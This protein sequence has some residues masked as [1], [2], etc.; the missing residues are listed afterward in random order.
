MHYLVTGGGGYIGS[1][2]ARDLLRQGARVTVVDNLSTGSMVLVNA[3]QR[4]AGANLQFV[5]ADLNDIAVL[6]EVFKQ[7]SFDAVFHFAASSVVGESMAEPEKYR[8]NNV[9]GT[10]KLL[11]FCSRH[12]VRKFIFS[13]T[14]SVYGEPGDQPVRESAALKPVSVYG[15]TKLQCERHIIETA[16]TSGNFQYMIFR[17]FNVAGASHDGKLGEVTPV[18]CHLLKAAVQAALGIRGKFS[19]FGDDYS[20][21]DG[22]GIRDYIHVEDLAAAHVAALDYLDVRGSNIFNVGYGY[23]YS[24]YQ[25][26]EKVKEVSGVDFRVEV[27]PRRAGDPAY[28]VADVEKIQAGMNWQP[29]YADL[30]LIVGSALEWERKL[31]KK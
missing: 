5:V 12:G 9:E 11:D 10:V 25:V 2:V 23:G 27:T 17:F 19:V 31:Q 1:H 14:A 15:E 4:A 16:L 30:D 13:S 24:V 8:S 22:T 20:T 18:F 7:P 26:I 3:L 6:E 21:P 29:R 28:L